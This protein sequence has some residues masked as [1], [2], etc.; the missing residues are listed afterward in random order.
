MDNVKDMNAP[1][2]SFG[3]LETGEHGEPEQP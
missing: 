1:D 2:D 3:E